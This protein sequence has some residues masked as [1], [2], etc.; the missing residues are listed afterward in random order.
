VLGDAM[1]Q[2]A[3]GAVPL[4]EDGSFSPFT[5]MPVGVRRVRVVKKIED[6]TQPLF[7]YSRRTSSDSKPSPER[8]EADVF[9]VAADGE[10]LAAMEGTQ[11]QR[12]GRSG[13]AGSTLDT[14]RW[15]YQIDWRAA[16]LPVEASSTDGHAGAVNSSG[17]EWLVFADAQGVARSLADQLVARGHSCVLVEPGTKYAAPS[18][19]S[20]NGHPSR[21]GCATIDPL[22]EGHY[23]RILEE[24]FGSTKQACAGIVHL[25]SLDIGAREPSPGPCPSGR[26]K[27]DDVALG[28][29]GALQ[30]IRALSRTSL[31]KQPPLWLVTAGAQAVDTA[32]GSSAAPIA[33][34][35]SP[36]IGFGRVA[37]LELPDFR[38][39]LVDLDVTN[40]GVQSAE[41]AAALVGDILNPNADGE[42]AYRHGKRYVARLA[43]STSME[44]AP[45]QQ[46][47]AQLAV[48]RGPFQLRIT[49]AGSFD[50]LKF[51][52][53]EREAPGPGQVE[54]EV[55]ATG[56]NFSDVLKALG[57]YPGIKDAI[58]P[59]GI[60]ASG[61]VIAVG[62]GVTRFE[63]GDEVLGVVPY[64]FASHART[65]DY[66]LVHKPKSIDHD[67]ACTI[68][69]TFL[70]AY[71]GLVRLAQLQPGERVLIHAGAGGVG[72][73]A[74]QIAQH[75]G[76][77]VFATAGSE[78]KR[79]FLRA[80]GVQHVYSSRSTAFADEILADTNREGVDIVLNSLPG[81]AITKSLAVLRAYGRFLEIGKTDIYQNRMIGLLPFQDNLSYFAIDLDRMLRQRPEYIRELFA[82]VMQH[83]DAGRYQPLMF[84]RFEAEST[85]DSFRYMS[86][87]KNI[88]KVVVSIEGRGS[89]VEG[90]ESEPVETSR[91]LVRGDGTYLI[92][93]G[94]GALGLRVAN[95][96]AEQGTGTIA[97]LAR[98]A[99]SH[100]SEQALDQ[101]RA[102]GARVVVL[103]GDVADAESLRGALAQLPADCPPLRGV[104]HAAGVLA[105]GILTEMTLDQLN[106]AMS[107][108]VRGT[109]NL[110][111]ITRELPLDFFVLFSSVASVLGSPGQANYAAGNAYLDALAHARRRQ[112]LPATAINWGPWAGSGMAAEAGRDESVKSRGMALIEPQDGL[113]LLGK[114]MKS[115]APQVAVM[116]AQW[117]DLLTLL[118]SR[119]PALLA[120]I[121]AEVQESGG[122]VGA[123]R[124]DHAFRQQLLAADGTT[125]QS[126]VQEY[127]RQELARIMGIEPTSL[128]TN[129]PL[130]TF[131]LDSLLALELKNNLEG[132][133]DFTLPM[134]KLMEGPSIESLAA[135]TTRLVAGG[136]ESPD[137][138][139]SATGG[140]NAEAWTPLLP[141]RETGSRPPLILLPGLGGDSRYYIELVR[142]LGDD[143]PVYVFRPRGLDQDLPP[144]LTIDETIGDYLPALRALQPAGPYHLAGWST[145]GAFAFAL[146]EA[147]E[148]SGE[149][150]ALLALL[151]SPLPS[152][153]DDV[154][155]EDDARFFCDLLNFANRCAGADARIDY[156]RLSSLPQAE[157]FSAGV[158]EARRSGMLPAETPDE[159]VRKLVDVG[160][161]NVRVLQSY[162]PSALSIPV[163]F[164]APEAREALAEVSGRT[165]PSDDDLGW[166]RLI[167]QTIELHRLPG[168]H[169]SMMFG[170]AAA[171]VARELA[172]Y[173]E[174]LPEPSAECARHS[175]TVRG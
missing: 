130:S 10:V 78:A 124:V 18:R 23:R 125:R 169:F 5:Y 50:A 99:P 116:N 167:G 29:G 165:P 118:G 135:E 54:I 74:I 151:D 43:R 134:A 115:A 67:A 63:I 14:S 42:V 56:L 36:M 101:T 89:R 91:A 106:R 142:Q 80:L 92:T 94:L 166:S 170:D 127:I 88:G 17:E 159:F 31:T 158:E 81:E 84:T 149:E 27:S 47:A 4:E 44:S 171:I 90:R 102:K 156:D 37:A 49:Q 123:S 28:C 137:A 128:E 133:L 13:T 83:F 71:Y 164:F 152:I 82:E 34:E 85:I 100:E 113:D 107:P 3:A 145:G 110:H 146:A 93:G 68:P 9:L 7:A 38:P 69:I 136:G 111:V 53:V 175:P 131:G 138:S 104:V 70:T 75:I 48:P 1:L 87:R 168:D 11:V 160:E 59:L 86:Q 21:H 95:W 22:D 174:P 154:D 150:V 105:D 61:V 20:T 162:R 25:W 39:R 2:A 66:A 12:L 172:R 117:S 139:T 24:V 19:S 76:A 114:L 109:W 41:A 143:Q 60:E 153:C 161:A 140:A 32:D 52:P 132:R 33:V 57:L 129:Q 163:Q 122:D 58:V 97:L 62:E 45:S 51:V 8:V 55:R 77:E 96:L 65:A 148:R 155:V 79:D 103:R 144:H 6:F 98:R 16:P 46:E 112:G 119:R 35:Q 40:A 26:G 121:A 126:L 64:A 72:L 120:E 147:L 15:L 157:Q 173:L 108:K 141:L 30:L 73:A